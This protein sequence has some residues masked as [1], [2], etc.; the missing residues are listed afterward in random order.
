MIQ[1]NT[2]NQDK[3]MLN[4]FEAVVV[5]ALAGK[6]KSYLRRLRC[7]VR[8]FEKFFPGT[9]VSEIDD[10]LLDSFQSQLSQD[11]HSQKTAQ[12]YRW[13][14]A[15]VVRRC[16]PH[17]LPDKRHRRL[18]EIENPDESGEDMLCVIY[19]QRFAPQRLLGKS[20][21]T[22]YFYPLAIYNLGHFLER[23]AR[24]SDLT[25]ENVAGMMAWIGA[26]GK[27]ARTVNNNRDYI[28]AF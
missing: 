12:S 5:P 13:N 4:F 21:R 1:Q 6:T 25:D 23:P 24:L 15:T 20:D 27:S 17:L 2:S 3:T 16:D 18:S 19:K 26:K 8:R 28:L 9:S 10:E 14:I 11:G 7:A 22:K